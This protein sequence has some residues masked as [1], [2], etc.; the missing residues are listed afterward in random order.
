MSIR[1]KSLFSGKIICCHCSKKF[2]AKKERSK[3]KYVCSSYDNKGEC[4]R[5]SVEED[6]L[7]ELIGRRLISPITRE[8]VEKYVDYIQ[9]ESADPYLLE[10]HFYDQDSILFSKNGIRF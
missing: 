6:Y 3:S 10:I 5:N 1:T 4:I 2:K 8:V 9:I 7:I